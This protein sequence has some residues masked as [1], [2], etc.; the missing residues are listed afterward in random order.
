[1]SDPLTTGTRVRLAG[2]QPPTLAT[3]EQIT[4]HWVLIRYDDDRTEIVNPDFV[5]RA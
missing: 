1:V 2:K 5:E 4:S 3:I